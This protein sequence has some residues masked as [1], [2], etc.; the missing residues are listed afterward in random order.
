VCPANRI[1]LGA[2][3][4]GPR[5]EGLDCPSIRNTFGG[6]PG[7]LEIPERLRP[8]ISNARIAPT[9][10]LD[11]EPARPGSADKAVLRFGT[12]RAPMRRCSKRTLRYLG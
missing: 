1:T 6:G 3:L 9:T 12:S 2:R 8:S 10:A 11:E 7:A 4:N 5:I